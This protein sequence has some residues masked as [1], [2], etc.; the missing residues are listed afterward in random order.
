MHTKRLLRQGSVQVVQTTINTDTGNSFDYRTLHLSIDQLSSPADLYYG[1]NRRINYDVTGFH[2]RK[3]SIIELQLN[4]MTL[5]C[6]WD[7]ERTS[8]RGGVTFSVATYRLLQIQQITFPIQHIGI[9]AHIH[10]N[11]PSRINA[12]QGGI[13]LVWMDLLLY[14]KSLSANMYV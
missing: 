1:R 8:I 5:V 13:F 10:C 7:Q 2:K 6:S 12:L 4:G 14:N 11:L 9:C 3:E